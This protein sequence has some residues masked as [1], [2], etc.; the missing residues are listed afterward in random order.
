MDSWHR[1]IL[2][3]ALYHGNFFY[4]G[5]IVFEVPFHFS[6]LYAII[7]VWFLIESI[8]RTSLVF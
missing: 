3:K 1:H 2:I 5:I 4:N 7:E 6:F 8:S